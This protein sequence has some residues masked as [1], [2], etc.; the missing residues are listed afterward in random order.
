MSRRKR[1]VGEED[2]DEYAFYDERIRGDAHR[3]LDDGPPALQDHG[4]GTGYLGRARQSPRSPSIVGDDEIRPTR[5]RAASPDDSDRGGERRA[6]RKVGDAYD[7]DDV[8]DEP[9]VFIEPRSI[10]PSV[11]EAAVSRALRGKAVVRD[12]C[13]YQEVAF[14]ADATGGGNLAFLRQQRVVDSDSRVRLNNLQLRGV[15]WCRVNTAEPLPQAVFVELVVVYDR[16]RIAFSGDGYNSNSSYA[17]YSWSDVFGPSTTTL[18]YPTGTEVDRAVFD[19]TN[20]E[21]SAQFRVMHRKIYK[22]DLLEYNFRHSETSG[23]MS[24]VDPLLDYVTNENTFFRIV[25]GGASP[26][27]KLKSSSTALVDEFVNLCGLPA[28]YRAGPNL[29]T[30]VDTEGAVY[31]GWRCSA[32][33]SDVARFKMYLNTR[34]NVSVPDGNDLKFF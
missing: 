27:Y 8:F 16:H 29:D 23:T 14:D 34:L 33:S 20:P 12:W 21:T 32:P 30:A 5:R 1:H 7:P 24:N 2:F 6:F 25:G 3:R 9:F 11:S 17:M 18:T 31:V 4:L 19:F 13:W 26:A 10:P 15:I 22:F 28:H